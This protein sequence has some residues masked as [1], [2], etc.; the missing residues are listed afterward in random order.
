M[1]IKEKSADPQLLDV[2]HFIKASR[3]S[4]VV[5]VYLQLVK[6]SDEI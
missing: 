2:P 4:N 3:R 6:P 5:S 1:N